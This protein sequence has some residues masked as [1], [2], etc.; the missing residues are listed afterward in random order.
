MS[1]RAELLREI[2]QLRSDIALLESRVG[3]L[4]TQLAGLD[5]FEL[6][7]S[8]PS[9]AATR[10]DSSVPGEGERVAAAIQT[11]QFFKRCLA[12]LP[13]G[14]SGRNRIRL[15]SRIYVVIRTYDGTLHT[16][17][18]LVFTQFSRV[19]ALVAEGGQGNQFGDSVFAGFASQWEAKRSVEEAGFTWPA[20]QA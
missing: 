11:G 16:D 7:G 20:S 18:V 2:Q 12:G 9:S 4:E 8:T 19:K 5:D 14:E 10:P 13:R 1:A 17:P 15:Q 3:A 6:V